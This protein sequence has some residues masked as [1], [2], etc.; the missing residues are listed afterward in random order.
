MFGRCKIIGETST[1]FMVLDSYSH[2]FMVFDPVL[3]TSKI[4][5]VKF[6]KRP[7][8][9]IMIIQLGNNK[10]LVDSLVLER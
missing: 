10:H 9:P 4:A 2:I 6:L 8:E 1:I 5:Q 7:L 3:L